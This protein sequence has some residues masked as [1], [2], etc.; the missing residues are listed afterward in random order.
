ML[1]IAYGANVSSTTM[2]ERCPA[3]KF[4]GTMAMRDYLLVFRGVADMVR[5]EG[6]TANVAVYEL[7][8]ECVESLNAFESVPS[9][10]KTRKID[11]TINGERKTALMYVMQASM[12]ERGQ[13]KPFAAYE[14]CL[15]EGY[16]EAGLPLADIDEAKQRAIKWCERNEIDPNDETRF[17]SRV[18]TPVQG[19]V[20]LAPVAA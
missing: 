4:L 16:A 3:A 11:V 2:T 5:A 12:K 6:K 20:V 1:Y 13:Q 8:D 17:L 15:R 7:S 14:E 10:Y 19:E 9:R 18:W